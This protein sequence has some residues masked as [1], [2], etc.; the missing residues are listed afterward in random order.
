[1][2]AST[3]EEIVNLVDRH[4]ESAAFARAATLAAT[5]GQSQIQYL[6]LMGEEAHLFQLL[7]NYVIYSDAS[8]RAPP[9][10]LDCT[11][12]A[13]SALWPFGISGDLPIVVVRIANEDHLPFVRQ[14]LR[15]H[16]YWRLRRLAV[17]L[18]IL[19][20]R[21]SSYAQDLQMALDKIVHTLD[22]THDQGGPL[23]RIFVV[24]GDLAGRDACNALRAAARVDLSSRR[25][26]LA[27]QL[28]A[29]E[30]NDQNAKASPT[31]KAAPKPQPAP[32]MALP[33]LQH[34]NGFGGFTP[35]GREYVIQTGAGQSTPAP[36][37]N[38]IANAK[39]G[40]QTSAEGAGY[41]WAMNSQQ[42][43][44]TQWSND[45]VSNESGEAIYL[46]D[47]DSGDV[48]SATASPIADPAV[49]YVARHGQGYSRFASTGR[50][51]AIDMV[52]FV[53]LSDCVKIS[54]LKIT[55]L[56]DRPRRLSL[57]H[58]A[59]WALGQLRGMSLPFI[60]TEIDPGTR[61]LFAR[62]PWNA[63][64]RE[65]VAFLDMRGIQSHWT[66]DRREF[67]GRN[68]TK[69]S[70]AALVR[71]TPLTGRVGPGLDPCGAQQTEISLAA[72][73]ATEIVLLL[74][75]AEGRDAARALIARY[76][77]ADLKAGFDAVKA[78]WD[79]TL[80]H[81]QIKTPDPAM[82][83]LVNRWLLYQ[84]LS[85][86]VWGRAGF[87]QASG[88]FGFRDQLQDGMAL[89]H[90]QPALVREHLLRAAGRQ[91]HE[92]DVQHWWLPESGKGVRSRI[93]DDKAWLAYTA[94][95]YLEATG[96]TALLDEPVAF[97]AGPLLREDE[98]DSFFQ[99]EASGESASFYEHCARALD[100]SLAIGEHG[101]PLMGTGDW[102][103][104]MNRVGEQGK[105]ESVWLG[106]FL[107]EALARFSRYAEARRDASRVANWLVHMAALRE[108][109]ATHGWD[110]DWYRRA[111]F[112]DG[113]AL[114]S[115]ANRECRID[116]I[117]QAWSVIS[118]AAPPDRQARAMEAVDKYLVRSEDRVLQLFAPP[119]VSS[120]HDPGYIKG[121]PAGIR[122]NG[123][124]YTHGA[125]WSIM[126]LAMM[127]NGDRA[128]ELF[129]MINPINHSR[130][131]SEAERYR[132]EPYVSCGDVY[133]MPPNVGRGG[134]TWYSGSAAWMYRTAVEYILGIRICGDRLFIA[135][136]IPQRWPSFEATIRHGS[137]TYEIR[138]DNAVH[139]SNGVSSI[140]LDGQAGDFRAGVPL[141]DDGRQHRIDV[142]MGT[143]LTEDNRR[144]V[145]AV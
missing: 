93:S 46:K 132:V 128:G 12:P 18:V 73:Q 7:A 2:A 42:N 130:T 100:A 117:A 1:M 70:P 32:T 92:G 133:A 5:H 119:F 139:R 97:I 122:E 38:V 47:L 142:V 60:V 31:V 135:P 45:P 27:D 140:S 75:W 108:A 23:G 41:C 77:T 141:V 112:D 64:F 51:I 44:I 43:K 24:R 111:F 144:P 82:D 65:Q 50:G 20:E 98:H 134:W 121:Y 63:D 6:G 74:G 59:E 28:D 25:G 110:G 136:A 83:L 14:L 68:G 57:T 62:N 69:E 116:S 138:V 131:R 78:Y 10:F 30:A 123:G 4:Q 107:H 72:G 76:R 39:F 22:R 81:I 67:L 101:L 15:A 29:L 34:F 9:E 145:L 17:D 99:P 129:A 11:A 88:A 114:G 120:T 126:A 13:A 125:L 8:L 19:N 96:D 90:S 3:R 91:F 103:D 105:G 124:Q 127:G 52:Q 54:R 49:R 61:A 86:R 94:A 56:S 109:L 106:W 115:A 87:Y 137:T 66:G 118:K 33:P 84:T 113:F 26:T 85:C 89:C 80:T 104:G 36:W 35:D 79:E 55:N 53:P 58:Y 48:W 102:N 143:P 16:D 71:N 40:F 37:I 95:H 21:P